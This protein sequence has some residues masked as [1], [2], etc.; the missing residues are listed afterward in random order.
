MTPVKKRRIA[1]KVQRTLEARERIKWSKKHGHD[2][3]GCGSASDSENDLG[4]VKV[5]HKMKKHERSQMY[6]LWIEFTPTF[7]SQQVP[8]QQSLL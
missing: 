7:L 5:E 4:A 8:F 2:T 3:Y 6:F 1:L